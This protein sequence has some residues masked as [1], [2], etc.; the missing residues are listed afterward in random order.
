M[1]AIIINIIILVFFIYKFSSF[2]PLH[3]HPWC[4]NAF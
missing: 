2:N 3:M 1:A 4:C